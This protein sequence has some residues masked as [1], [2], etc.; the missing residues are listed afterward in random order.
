SLGEEF[1]NDILLGRTVVVSPEMLTK[2][3][4]TE[5]QSPS[6]ITEE[7]PLNPDNEKKN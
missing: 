5:I 4:N 3:L 2:N 7:S 1:F 6:N